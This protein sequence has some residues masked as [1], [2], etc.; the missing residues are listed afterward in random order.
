MSSMIISIPTTASSPDVFWSG[1]SVALTSRR[2]V[3]LSRD[4]NGTRYSVAP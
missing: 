3:L 1:T 4:D 2:G